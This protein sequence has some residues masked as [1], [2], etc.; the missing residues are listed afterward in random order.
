MVRR[1]VGSVT[2]MSDMNDMNQ[3][4]IDEFRTNKGKVS[5]FGDADVVIVHHVGAKT[6]KERQTPLVSRVD[7]DK[8]IIFATKGGAPS[9][10]DWYRNLVANPKVRIEI[11]TETR[12]VVARVAEGEERDRFWSRQK[13][14]MPAFAEY[15]EKAGARQIPVVV[16]E[17]AS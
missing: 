4:V 16:L 9:H 15:E 2:G 17:P 10:P 3:L 12:D 14:E 7:G 8:V 11:G 6:G 1:D 5:Y 13:E